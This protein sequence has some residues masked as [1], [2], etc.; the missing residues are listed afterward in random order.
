MNK[1]FI[2][3]RLIKSPEAHIV[4]QEIPMVFINIAVKRNFKDKNGEYG[5]DF[6]RFK[7]FKKTA[8]YINLYLDKGDLVEIE[9]VPVN[10]NYDNGQGMV[11]KDDYM[12]KN[13]NRLTKYKKDD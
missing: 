11:F 1:W 2:V 4:G 10:A 6:F 7:A 3:G 5:A 12:I 8:E 13:I 9:A